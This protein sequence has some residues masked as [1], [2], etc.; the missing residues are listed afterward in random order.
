MGY[1]AAILVTGL[2]TALCSFAGPYLDHSSLIMIYL[3]SAVFIA[4]H[5]GR[6]PSILAS[7]LAVGEFYYFCI[8]RIF[9]FAA[10]D[11]QY[12]I[13][14][15]AML[16]ITIL[17]TTFTSEIQAK[18]E[19]GRAREKRSEALRALSTDMSLLRGR[20]KLIV[21]ALNHVRTFFEAKVGIYLPDTTGNLCEYTADSGLVKIE[22]QTNEIALRAF[23][24]R[25]ICGLGKEPFAS[26]AS[27]YL[28]LI[29]SQGVVGVLQVSPGSKS[30]LTLTDDLELLETFA[31]QTALCIEVATLSERT[32]LAAIQIEREQ[33]RNVLLSSVSH[34]LR[35]PLATITG[36]SSSLVEDRLSLNE[37]QKQELA[38]VIL[39]EA[40]HLNNHVRNLLEMTKLESGPLTVK[41]RWHSIEETV[42]ACMTRLERHL[43]GR[44][45]HIQIPLD[46]PLVPFDEILIQQVFLNLLENAMKYTPPAS[47][48]D[49]DAHVEP[50]GK[51]TP[52]GWIEITISDRG[53]GLK[54]GEEEKIFI[55][56]YRSV[57]ACQHMGVGLGLAICR[58]IIKAH[59]GT[60]SAANR[61][62]GGAEFRIRLPLDGV[63][64][65]SIIELGLD[66]FDEAIGNNTPAEAGAQSDEVV[67]TGEQE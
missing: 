24:N 10:T 2:A 38:Q 67:H 49:I 42:G 9:S 37:S 61:K 15:A 55:K 40:E 6:G 64:P 29:A 43:T 41:K 28:P 45:I 18:A 51:D 35:T 53:P 65:A 30:C 63:P 52:T 5:F 54:P 17:I 3:L 19:L 4:V 27:L 23:Q 14:L 33:L 56:F 44:Q 47:D 22:R 8:L 46:L 48:I 58:A 62:G 25:Q 36:A 31:N 13:S 16:A 11:A 21:V 34:D 60:I 20:D 66:E 26:A 1:A 50:A 32:Q 39:E 59:G 7:L 12:V 57:A